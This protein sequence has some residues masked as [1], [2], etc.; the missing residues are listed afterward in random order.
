MRTGSESSMIVIKIKTSAGLASGH[1]ARIKLLN[2]NTGD[3]INSKGLSGMSDYILIPNLSPSV[4]RPIEIGLICGQ[5]TYINRISEKNPFYSNIT[6]TT[7]GVYFIGSWNGKVTPVSMFKADVTIKND[8]NFVVSEIN[9][10][11]CKKQNGWCDLP[12]DN[13]Q[14]IFSQKEFLFWRNY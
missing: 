5:V 13:L 14:S 8:E 7:P 9:K 12:V 1:G 2:L 10:I 3:T 6:I 4:Y 11:L